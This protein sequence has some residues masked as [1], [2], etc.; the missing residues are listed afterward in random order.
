MYYFFSEMVPWS[1]QIMS[2]TTSAHGFSQTQQGAMQ[3]LELVEGY[4]SQDEDLL[5]I[6]EKIK[7]YF[8]QT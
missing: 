1:T 7:V 5:Q 3:F 8:T 2:E 6:S 4:K